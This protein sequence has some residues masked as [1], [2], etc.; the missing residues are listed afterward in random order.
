MVVAFD[1]WS[2]GASAGW[3]QLAPLPGPW[4]TER[5]MPSARERPA[6]PSAAACRAAA[7]R[8]IA[9]SV[10]EQH[11]EQE[12]SLRTVHIGDIGDDTFLEMDTWCWR[13]SPGARSPWMRTG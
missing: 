5:W 1:G 7:R 3:Q 13:P 12:G 10:L 9:E 6:R 4:R 11:N 8:E 2:T